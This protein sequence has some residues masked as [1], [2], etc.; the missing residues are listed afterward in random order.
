MVQSPSHPVNMS[1]CQEGHLEQKAF[2]KSNLQII[3][4]WVGWGPDNSQW[5]Q[6]KEEEEDLLKK[7]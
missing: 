6:P 7:L 1:K 2:A 4:S 5:E 3:R